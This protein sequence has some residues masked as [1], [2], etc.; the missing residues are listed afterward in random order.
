MFLCI[1]RGYLRKTLIIKKPRL[2][3]ELRECVR[4]SLTVKRL[5]STF[6]NLTLIDSTCPSHLHIPHKKGT[7]IL[8]E[9]C[10][11]PDLIT[12]DVNTEICIKIDGASIGPMKCSCP[13]KIASLCGVV[14]SI[15]E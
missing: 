10:V 6:S 15:V 7:L 12:F 1:N 14:I 2:Q 4:D 11:Y 9:C 8:K 5:V 13:M 3:M